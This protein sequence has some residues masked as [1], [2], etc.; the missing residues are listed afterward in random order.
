VFAG[1]IEQGFFGL[2]ARVAA[3]SFIFSVAMT[4]LLQREFSRAYAAANQAGMRHLFRRYVP[5]LYTVTA[6]FAVFASAETRP[7]VAF[8]GGADFAPAVPATMIMALYPIHQTYGQLGGAIFL[9]TDRTALYRNIG[10]V[11]MVAGLAA[12]WFVLAPGQWGG[13]GGGSESLAAKLVVTQFVMVNVQFWF[14]TRV[15]QLSFLQFLRHQIGVVATFLAI[16]WGAIGLVG[17]ARWPDLVSFLASGC[18]YTAGVGAVLVRW[19]QLA[20]LS[21]SDVRRVAHR[22]GLG[23]GR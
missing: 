18:L 9:A 11:G 12:T 21:S 7:L 13:L 3:V 16:A 2:G 17:L 1:S 14:N 5:L 8:I 20:G 6:Y 10:V 19:P 22:L 23:E 15:L 4:Q